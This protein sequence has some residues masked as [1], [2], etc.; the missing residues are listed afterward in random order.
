MAVGD[1]AGVRPPVVHGHRRNDLKP[2][3]ISCRLRRIQR[4]SPPATHPE[5]RPSPQGP[6]LRSGGDRSSTGVH[7]LAYVSS[8]SYC[9]SV[10]ILLLASLI[11]IL[12][13]SI[14]SRFR[15]VRGCELLLLII[16]LV[17]A[18]DLRIDLLFRCTRAEQQ[19]H[20]APGRPNYGGISFLETDCVCCLW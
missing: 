17:S 5:K 6:Q 20:P 2:A 7:N 4:A 14:Y 9:C 8:S 3:A 12:M 1:H 11:P 18:L 15:S 13:T 10:L 16:M 19:P